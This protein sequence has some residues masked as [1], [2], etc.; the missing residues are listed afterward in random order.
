MFKLV[1]RLAAPA[2]AI[3][4]SCE[5]SVPSHCTRLDEQCSYMY[6]KLLALVSTHP[7][8]HMRW[9]LHFCSGP[10]VMPV[11]IINALFSLEKCWSIFFLC[12]LSCRNYVSKSCQ[13]YNHLQKITS[14][15]H[16][17]WSW[18]RLL[19]S[20]RALPFQGWQG[21]AKLIHQGNSERTLM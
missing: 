17:A 20:V 9:V 15:H 1:L 3:L 19:A 7:C 12:D 2:S 14:G 10:F 4:S 11:N 16:L 21:E 18:A 8:L 13:D 6:W 5:P